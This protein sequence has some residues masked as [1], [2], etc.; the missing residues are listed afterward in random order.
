[1]SPRERLEGALRGT[2]VEPR[3]IIGVYG[4]ARAD[5][6]V[7]EPGSPVPTNGG[8]FLVRVANPFSRNPGMPRLLHDDPVAGGAALLS[9]ST[10]AS[11]EISAALKSGAAGIFYE[12]RGAA[13]AC[14]TPMEYGGHFLEVDRSLLASASS[15]WLNVVFVYGEEPYLDFVSDL[16]A[17]LF[18][19]PARTGDSLDEIR[20]MRGGLLTLD[21]PLADVA[22]SP[23]VLA[24]SRQEVA[25]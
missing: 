4:D 1:M 19:W 11:D 23:S 13:P 3:P 21:H 6:V 17:Q 7:I 20:S 10:K 14:T 25:V 16:P 2:V 8:P 24:Q 18:G 22:L 12:I 9:A 5:A 15:A